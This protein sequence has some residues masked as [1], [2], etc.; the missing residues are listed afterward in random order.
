MRI[1]QQ[2]AKEENKWLKD[3]CAQVKQ[4]IKEFCAHIDNS[5]LK[6]ASKEKN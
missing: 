4:S 1:A 6:F 5:E 2:K 3:Q